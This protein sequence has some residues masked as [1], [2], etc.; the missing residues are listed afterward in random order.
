MEGATIKCANAFQNAL[1]NKIKTNYSSMPLRVLGPSQAY[2][3]KV[4]NK[5]RYKT[6]I[7][8]RNSKDF[9][10]VIKE[11]LLEFSKNKEF[12]NIGITVDINPLSFN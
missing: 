5:Y 12:K 4:N 2:V 10:S 6:I 1:I 8:C 7:K 3:Y 9:R 11:T